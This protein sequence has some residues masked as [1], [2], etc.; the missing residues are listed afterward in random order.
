MT[1]HDGRTPP[2]AGGGDGYLAVISPQDSFPQTAV[3]VNF[4]EL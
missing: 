4:K 2:E 3:T 1:F